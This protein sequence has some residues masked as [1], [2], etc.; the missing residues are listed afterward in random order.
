MKKFVLLSFLGSFL[1]IILVF[2]VLYPESFKVPEIQKEITKFFKIAPSP[3]DESFQEWR[4]QNANDPV[5]RNMLSENE[6]KKYESDKYNFSYH[7]D[8]QVEKAKFVTLKSKNVSIEIRESTLKDSTPSTDIFEGLEIN[9]GEFLKVSNLGEDFS[10]VLEKENTTL[11]LY[12][13]NQLPNE[14]TNY[15]FREFPT[16]ISSEG[17]NSNSTFPNEINVF[18]NQNNIFIIKMINSNTSSVEEQVVDKSRYEVFI[19]RFEIK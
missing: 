14:I 15:V 18:M 19:E 2:A 4:N 10:K 16:V 13:V 1:T 9:L 5:A 17:L 8:W 7:K 11:K 6:F 3:T 12:T